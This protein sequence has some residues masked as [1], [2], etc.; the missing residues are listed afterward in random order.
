MPRRRR[1]FP[2]SAPGTAAR[3]EFPADRKSSW[4]PPAICRVALIVA[5]ALCATTGASAAPPADVA[6]DDTIA[7][8]LDRIAR[9]PGDHLT[10]VSLGAA[11]LR[12]ARATGD[13]ALHDRAVE[14]A[15]RSLRIQRDHA[16][17]LVLLSAA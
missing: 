9:D 7:F 11:Y 12:K 2:T 14:A 1:R 8:Y 13:V 15:E 17:A 10:P 6:V 16:P 5:L 3:P 4:A